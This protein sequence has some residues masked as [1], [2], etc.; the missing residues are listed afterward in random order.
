MT[1]EEVTNKIKELRDKG[2]VCYSISRLNT[3]DECPLE[4]WKTYVEHLPSKDNIYSF[5]GTKIHSCLESFQNGINIDFPKEV[6]N[7]LVEA[8]TLDILFPNEKIENSWVK[9]IRTFAKDYVKPNYKKVETE[10]KFIFELD[11]IYL[12]GIIDLVIYNDDGTVSIVDYK[13]SSKFS[14]ADLESKGRQLILY[15][16]AMEQMG[17]KVKDLAWNMLKYNEVS[18]K[19][20]NGNTRTTIAERGF[21]LEKL[22]SDITKRLKSTKQYSDIEI[23]MMVEEAITNNSFDN[24]PKEIKDSYDIYDYILYYDFSIDRKLET[25]NFIRAKVGDIENFKDRE[26]WWEPREITPY[27]S[28]Y[29]QYLCGHRQTCEAFAEFQARQEYYEKL[30]NQKDEEE[31]DIFF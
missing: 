17:Y 29:C 20:K 27:T 1:N 12:Q 19:L 10:K 6:D 5:T 23:E 13:T 25:E 26:E 31:E 16:L 18:Y 8:K 2:I 30:K 4:Y 15:G 21:L 7:M 3:V 24:L 14:N 22:K 9:N 28:F 11:G